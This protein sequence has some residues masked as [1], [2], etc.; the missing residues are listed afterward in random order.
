VLVRLGDPRVVPGF[1]G[2][3]LLDML[4][5]KTAGSPSAAFAQ[6]FANDTGLRPDLK[7]SALPSAPIIRFRWVVVFAATLVRFPL[8]PAEL[9]ASLAD[10]AGLFAQ[11]PETFTPE[12][13]AGRSPFPLSGMTTV[14]TEQAPPV[15]LAPTG[16]SV[17]PRCTRSRHF[18]QACSLR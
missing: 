8:R 3:F 17:E 16:M 14:V 10:L 18:A 7:G 9:L 11:P 13:S 5:S 1:H 4:S 2:A 6:F 15:G 12:L